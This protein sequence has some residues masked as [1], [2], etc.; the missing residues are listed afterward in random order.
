LYEKYR[1]RAHFVIVDLDQRRSPA[2]QEL[3]KKYY[4]GYI[5]HVTILDKNGKAIYDR[6]GEADESKLSAILD[7][8]LK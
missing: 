8:A 6:A 3:V 7:G 5:P 4:Q 2:Q 1:G